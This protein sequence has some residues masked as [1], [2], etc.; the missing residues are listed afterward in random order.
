[1]P[2]IHNLGFPRIGARRELKRALE[3]YW[4]GRL[5]ADELQRRGAE[6][7]RRHWRQ[8]A[9]AGVDPV[10]VG[11][12]SWYDHVLDVTA[13]LGVIPERFAGNPL[14]LDTRFHMARGR[15]AG[16][17][18]VAPCPM[19]KWFDTNYHYIVPELEA[20]SRFRA[21]PAPLVAELA[22]ARAEGHTPK[23]VLVGPLTWLRLAR[24]IDGSDPLAHADAL[25]E[26]YAR[27]LQGLGE[28]GADWVQLDEPALATDLP[29]DWW[30]AAERIYDALRT[31]PVRVLLAVYF[32]DAGP[33]Q[34]RL[35]S[36][37]VA[38]LHL[39]G[40]RA[41]ETL[42]TALERWDGERVLSA[43]VIDGRNV[44]RSDLDA[45]AGRLGPAAR[46]L[47][48]A[49]WL[50]PSCPL[51]HV[52]VDLE[53]ETRLPEGLRPRLA[54]AVQ[55]LDEL[56]ELARR[57]DAA[58]LPA[59][60]GGATATTR[61]EDVVFPPE[62]LRRRRPYPERAPR[63]R[64]HLRLPRVP[65]TTIG[66]L[67][68]T[69]EIRRTRRDWRAGR[70]DDAAYET[71]MRE[72]IGQAIAEQEALGLDVLVHGEAER[73]DMV[74]YFGERLEGIAT[75]AGGWVQSYGSRC[76]KPPIVH[77]A[78]SRPGPITV[79]WFRHAQSLTERPVKG[80]LTGPV[81]ILQWSFV[82][83]DQPRAETARQLAE[84]LRAE[85]A[86]LEAA[87]ARIIQID[88]PALREGLPL[89]AAER[90]DYLRWAVDAFRLASA[91]VDDSTQI[92]T[93]MCYSEFGDIL[94]AI[95]ELDADVITIEAARSR[96]AL[97]DAFAEHG[98]PNEI[99]PG[100]YDIHSPRVPEQQEML[101]LLE[102][103]ARVFPLERLWANPDCGLKTRSWA[104]IRPALANLV[105]AAR[106]LRARHED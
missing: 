73:N 99:G 88:E 27:L 54:F 12:F 57:L 60:A 22:E 56:G 102:A 93:H 36:L 1:M 24:P 53:G 89:R 9:A 41:T 35:E 100:I 78:I 70:L 75:T 13:M 38:G 40:V 104:E 101:A 17:P 90:P 63:Q 26:A 66:S 43:G 87:G 49:L 20:A 77:G 45:L 59:S 84:A 8:Q 3:G 68:Q 32:G 48:D 65:T 103:A 18:D 33:W 92:H 23:P 62:R 80:M 98:Y 21:D 39:D 42:A 71:R 30:A 97:L 67:P 46:R 37:P 61:A 74:E 82:R 4:A 76:V 83:T 19:T 25:A 95:T 44:W 14:D 106:T 55:K 69:A 28:A 2:R 34:P 50:A 91:G 16:R 86:E 11:D 81:T 105:A 29:Q 94:D 72:E 5:D 6:L 58:E 15:A 85:V 7:R 47:G 51:L 52:P 10:P 64:E 96:M 31:G 79:P